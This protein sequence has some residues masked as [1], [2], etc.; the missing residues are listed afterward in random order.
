MVVPVCMSKCSNNIA[1]FPMTHVI[2]C[3]KNPL[4]LSL[5]RENLHVHVHV[6]EDSLTGVH[7]VHFCCTYALIL[8]VL[9]DM[10]GKVL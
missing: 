8:F 7:R 6:Y 1:S 4:H 10:V 5:A 2:M 3:S 9:T